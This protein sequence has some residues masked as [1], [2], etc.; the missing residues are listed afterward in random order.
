MHTRSSPN[1]QTLNRLA[2]E[3]GITNYETLSKAALFQKLSEEFNLDRLLR[4]EAR[5]QRIQE[6]LGATKKK[7]KATDQEVEE[8]KEGDTSNPSEP[9]NSTS[10]TKKQKKMSLNTLDPIM[11]VPIGKKKTFK[12][13]RPNGS[14]VQFN[15]D[16]L[17][18]FMIASGDFTDPETRLSFTDDQLRE[19]DAIAADIG[20]EKPSVYEAKHNTQFYSDAK[21]RR[22]ALLGLERCA[23]EVVADILEL[24][25]EGEDPDDA[26]M[27]L[28]MQDF[29]SFVDYF[30][31][32]REA[33]PEYAS[34]CISHWKSF[35]IGPPNHPNEDEF[36]LLKLVLKFLKNCE[37]GRF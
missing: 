2:V 9:V 14:V 16:S 5:K 27:Q 3:A 15:V 23:G 20:L 11:L 22:D 19:I 37:E 18:D 21:F 12:F 28:A 33:D 25:E 4:I 10:R 31:Q 7:R 6:S 26:Q 36:G 30:R 29:P 17:V 13:H 32:I 1:R 8:F 34:K 24:I 35:I